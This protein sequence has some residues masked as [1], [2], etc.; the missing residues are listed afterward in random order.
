MRRNFPKIVFEEE[1]SISGELPKGWFFLKT[2]ECLLYL[3]VACTSFCHLSLCVTYTHTHTHTPYVCWKTFWF[4]I[5]RANF[6]LVKLH[7]NLAVY[8]SICSFIT[9]DGP[10]L[11]VVLVILLSFTVSVLW[12]T[13]HG[14]QLFCVINY[15]LD[16]E[17]YKLQ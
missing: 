1:R 2:V 13:K 6:S 11:N 9:L 4:T 5:F 10:L 3:I 16:F 14:I 8:Y 17:I 12:I 7:E 15:R